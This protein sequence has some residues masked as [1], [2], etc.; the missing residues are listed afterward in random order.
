MPTKI[1]THGD[2]PGDLVIK[3]LPFNAEDTGSIPGWGTKI[4]Q[5]TG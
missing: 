1:D 2:F 3:K 4:P 5:A